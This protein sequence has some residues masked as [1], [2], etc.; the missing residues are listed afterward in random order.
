MNTMSFAGA[1]ASLGY[2][3]LFWWCG[4]ALARRALPGDGAE[5]L[6]PLSG[7]FCTALLAGLPA[8]FALGLG[9]TLPAVLAA[10]AAALGLGLWATLRRKQPALPRPGK[11]LAALTWDQVDLDAGV[12]R[13]PGQEVPLTNAVRRLLERARAARRPEDDPMCCSRPGPGG[14]W[15]WPACPGWCRRR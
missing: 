7:A 8:V 13:L 2:L 11:D 14:P 1:V 15:I 3:A 9:F 12:L 4:W 6:L 10:G 5:V